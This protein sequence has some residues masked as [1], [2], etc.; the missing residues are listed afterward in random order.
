MSGLSVSMSG[1]SD[2]LDWSEANVT[3]NR[4][5]SWSWQGYTFSFSSSTE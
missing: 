1:G 4:G 5:T 3:K 2:T